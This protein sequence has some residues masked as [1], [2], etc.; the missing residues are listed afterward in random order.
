MRRC[1]TFYVGIGKKCRI[2]YEGG[3]WS[4]DGEDCWEVGVWVGWEIVSFLEN[5][6]IFFVQ[7]MKVVIIHGTF[8]SPDENWF[9]WLKEQLEQKG[10]QIWI[11]RLPTPQD[12]TPI[13]WS[14]ELQRQVPFLF[15]TDTD[16][17]LIGHSLGATY[18]LHI[19]DQERAWPV[20]RAIFVSGFADRLGIDDFDCLNAP[21]IEREF[22]REKIKSNVQDIVFL[23]GDDDPY[24][25]IEK[26]EVLH[27]HLGGV[28]QIIPWGGHLNAEAGYVKF[29]EMLGY[30][31]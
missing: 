23:H 14:N 8:W 30:V 10:H 2:G 20:G 25:P 15:D 5:S 3:V 16:T 27:N 13:V 29:E 17:V 18:L 28:F 6:F 31:G 12:Q 22:D 1:D 21:F 26:A 9:P 4:E 11:P 7:F 24:V 19:L